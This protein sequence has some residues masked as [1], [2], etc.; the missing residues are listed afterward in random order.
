SFAAGP[1]LDSD[2]SRYFTPVAIAENAQR[3]DLKCV[4]RAG[5]Q[6]VDR[7]C[8]RVR[9]TEL[10]PVSRLA[11][12]P[13][14]GITQHVGSR[15]S[16]RFA[17]DNE[18]TGHGPM[19]HANDGALLHRLRRNM[20]LIHRLET[21]CGQNGGI[22]FTVGFDVV[23]EWTQHLDERRALFLFLGDGFLTAI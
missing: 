18:L 19:S 20:D 22:I 23:S 13:D 12:G 9:H 15:L 8:A 21:T 3:P 11:V 6:A 4:V 2:T 5:R 10:R 14:R 7:N 17:F 1:Q 16:L